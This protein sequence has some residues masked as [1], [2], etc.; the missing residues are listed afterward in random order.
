M[1]SPKR[2]ITGTKSKKRNLHSGAAARAEPLD[3]ALNADVIIQQRQLE[4]RKAK[5]EADLW[6]PAIRSKAGG[7]VGGQ[8]GQG[9]MTE[10]SRKWPSGSASGD[11]YG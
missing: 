11:I 5:K 10:W 3:V 6:V 2:G 1:E 4:M 7:D 8:S 9:I